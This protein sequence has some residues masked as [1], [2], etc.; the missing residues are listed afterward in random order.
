M[1]NRIYLVRIRDGSRCFGNGKLKSIFNT[2]Y[3][4][5]LELP[6]VH[7]DAFY[8]TEPKRKLRR[9]PVVGWHL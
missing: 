4:L 6:T 3:V 1:Y 9:H 7:P 5:D 2:L 8:T